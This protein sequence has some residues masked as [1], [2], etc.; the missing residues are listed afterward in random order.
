MKTALFL[1]S[2]ISMIQSNAGAS[3]LSNA[4]KKFQEFQ[5]SQTK[6][7]KKII[8][9]QDEELLNL[10]N[11]SVQVILDEKED[12]SPEFLKKLVEVSVMT[13]ETDPSLAAAELIYP[14]F[15]KKT[16]SMETAIKSLPT[17]EADQLKDAFRNLAREETDGNG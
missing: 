14:L 4:Q 1:I 10:I 8:Y 17:K 2:V 13:F 5:V 7:E 3:T 6:T 12:P 9:H 15:K 11:N 16:D